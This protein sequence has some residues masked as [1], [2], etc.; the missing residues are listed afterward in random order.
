MSDEKTH[1]LTFETPTAEEERQIR[2]GLNEYVPEKVVN[3]LLENARLVIGKGRRQEVF[4][5][6]LGD[7]KSGADRS[8]RR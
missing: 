2:Q 3:H 7:R 4:L 8:R 1:R 6:S 5:I